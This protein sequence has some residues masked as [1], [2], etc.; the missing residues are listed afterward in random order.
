MLGVFPVTVSRTRDIGMILNVSQWN[1]LSPIE[2]VPRTLKIVLKGISFFA[3]IKP[4]RVLRNSE[5]GQYSPTYLGAAISALL[6]I[7]SRS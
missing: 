7:F 5:I 1:P 3:T 2:N 6:E 4:I